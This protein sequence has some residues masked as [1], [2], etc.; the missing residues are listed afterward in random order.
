MSRA[1]SY[2]ATLALAGA[3]LALT[4]GCTSLTEP[5]AITVTKEKEE[6]SKAPAQAAPGAAVAAAKGAQP[7]GAQPGGAQPGAQPA[8]RPA[9]APAPAK[10]GSCGE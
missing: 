2:L 3:F 5:N 1:K 4:T 7:G 9:P 8:N 6:P 10:G